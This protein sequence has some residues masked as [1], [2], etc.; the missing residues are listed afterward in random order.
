MNQCALA[1]MKDWGDVVLGFGESD[2]Y[3]FVLPRRA[4]VF[5]RRSAKLST[6][7]A[8]QFA[9]AFVFHWARFFPD[10]PLKYPPSFD[11]RCVVYPTLASICDYFRWRQVDAHINSLHNEAFWA[12]VTLGGLNTNEAYGRLQ[13]TLSEEKHEILFGRFDINFAKL[14]LLFRR[15]TTLARVKDVDRLRAEHGIAVDG[16]SAIE[17]SSGSVTSAYQRCADTAGRGLDSS[18]WGVS[19]RP[20]ASVD[21]A[22]KAEQVLNGIG[23]LEVA[24]AEKPAQTIT[25]PP[26][27]V[28]PSGVAMIFPDYNRATFIRE[29]DVPPSKAFPASDAAGSSAAGEVTGASDAVSNAQVGAASA[30]RSSSSSRLPAKG[31]QSS[32]KGMFLEALFEA[33]D[34]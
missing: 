28:L 12:L 17:D 4:N 29:R 34:T 10:T 24:S 8:S 7:I 18:A 14:P 25:L 16:L 13:K 27:I 21:G 22:A 23:K 11:A 30:G 1:V 3:S 20:N 5:G 26:P 9:A 6:G 15:G 2:E 33:Y 31:G 32:A 19:L